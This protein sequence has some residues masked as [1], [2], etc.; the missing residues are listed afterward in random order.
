MLPEE[1]LREM[2]TVGPRPS[3]ARI[4][5]QP[6]TS[7]EAKYL[8]SLDDRWAHVRRSLGRESFDFHPTVKTF[9]SAY[10]QRLKERREGSTA[11]R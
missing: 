6:L 11:L 10:W 3:F 8:N 4:G 2:F 5:K 9:E 7:E 1:T